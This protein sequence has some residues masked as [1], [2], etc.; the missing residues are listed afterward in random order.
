MNN[1]Y[2]YL[3]NSIYSDFFDI[4][5]MYVTNNS[6]IKKYKCTLNYKLYKALKNYLINNNYLINIDTLFDTLKPLKLSYKSINEVE[7]TIRN[8]DISIINNEVKNIITIYEEF[9]K[10]DTAIYT[11]NKNSDYSINKYYSISEETPDYIL[12]YMYKKIEEYKNDKLL[13]TFKTIIELYNKDIKKIT[14][15]YLEY[16]SKIAS[17]SSNL[18]YTLKYDNYSK[19]YSIRKEE[20]YLKEYP[21]FN[22]SSPETKNFYRYKLMKKINPVRY[23]ER[24]QLKDLYKKGSTKLYI[25][26]TNYSFKILI[27]FNNIDKYEDIDN[28]ISEY[29][30][31]NKDFIFYIKVPKIIENYYTNMASDSSNFL[32]KYDDKKLE[33]LKVKYIITLES[34]EIKINSLYTLINILEHPNNKAYKKENGYNGIIGIKFKYK[35]IY[36][37]IYN[38]SFYN[39]YLKN[40]IEV[41]K[42][43]YI[44]YNLTDKNIKI[45]NN[46]ATSIL[47]NSRDL[48]LMYFNGFYLTYKDKEVL[49]NY[50]F[51]FD[52]DG[53]YIDTEKFTK[54]IKNNYIYENYNSKNTNIHIKTTLIKDS[55]VTKIEG[56]NKVYVYFDTDYDIAKKDKDK[57]IFNNNKLFYSYTDG[58]IGKLYLN[59]LNIYERNK[60]NINDNKYSDNIKCICYEITGKNITVI[61]SPKDDI[62]VTSKEIMDKSNIEEENNESYNKLIYYIENPLYSNYK[63]SLITY[64]TLDIENLKKFNL[65]NSEKYIIIDNINEELMEDIIK[66][67]KYLEEKKINIKFV[68]IYKNS[69]EEMLNRYIYLY[70]NKSKD[71]IKINK[72]DINNKE[73]ILLYIGARTNISSSRLE[74]YIETLKYN[75]IEYNSI[76]SFPYNEKLYLKNT[77]GGFNK[78]NELV[79]NKFDNYALTN[80]IISDNMEII[81]S[82]FYSYTLY[83]KRPITKECNIYSES[84]EEILIN[85][86]K[87]IYNSFI[88]KEGITERE[89]ERENTKVK[90]LETLSTIDNVKIYKIT[91]KSKQNANIKLGLHL[92][93]EELYGRYHYT[94]FDKE[95]NIIKITSTNNLFI[96]ATTNIEKY[97]NDTAIIDLKLKENKEIEVAFTLGIADE[98]DTWFLKEKYSNLSTID[99]AIKINNNN[100]TNE[101]HRLNIKTKTD[102]LNILF[103]KI[104]PYNLYINKP[105]NYELSLICN[106]FKEYSLNE[107]KKY[108]LDILFINLINKYIYY[109]EDYSLINNIIYDKLNKILLSSKKYNFIYK[110]SVDSFIELS[111]K[112]GHKIDINKYKKLKLN[113]KENNANIYKFITENDNEFLKLF[114]KDQVINFNHNGYIIESAAIY[115][116]AIIRYLGININSEKL[117]ITKPLIKEDYEFTYKY[118][119]SMYNVKVKFTN[120]NKIAY[121]SQKVT[122]KYVKL[123]NDLKTHDITFEIKKK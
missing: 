103:N 118:F 15:G 73:L 40:K 7:E 104:I 109:Y 45:D 97:V 42:L 19:L 60:I 34:K 76:K 12:F 24:H 112:L 117:S 36:S 50:K 30:D 95:K 1:Y 102:K 79:I 26:K 105:N 69:D 74:D 115:Y 48:N 28:I 57:I 88:V 44:K 99:T 9:K 33:N 71:I 47:L 5:K 62:V 63:S 101:L 70:L 61:T 8:I 87:L 20:S 92:N 83:N 31:T 37:Y 120:K 56:I 122:T 78:D 100:L 22:I 119:N 82:P 68:F 93:F 64:N 84:S 25:N 41:N 55:L 77:Y 43:K 85:N 18:F 106:I 58:E 13:K 39:K 53:K 6:Y 16:S 80:K 114:K 66:F 75:K 107:I 32:E 23:L 14:E 65:N 54:Q 98:K 67:H 116:Y 10:I 4:T 35:N 29:K 21:L 52:I 96:T 59:K 51:I 86:R 91:I 90:V 110:E 49:K 111:K 89:F 72:K 94:E 81:T 27:I 108:N 113:Y 11:S 3:K 46:V 2:L 38:Y 123:K 17:K 121:D